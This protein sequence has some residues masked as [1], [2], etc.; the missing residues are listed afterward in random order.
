MLAFGT[1]VEVSI[2]TADEALAREAADTVRAD[3]EYMHR[4]WHPWERGALGRTNQLLAMG[5]W[6]SVNPSVLPLLELSRELE[7]LSDGLFNPAMGELI[8]LWGFHGDERTGEP[9]P[10]E[11]RIREVLARGPSMDHIEIDGIRA[12]ATR[13]GIRLDPGGF[14]KGY[15]VDRAMERLIDMGIEH[16]IINAGGDL[17]AIGRPGDRPWRIGIRH[18]DGESVIASLELGGDESVYT[19]GDYERFFEFDGMRYHHILDPRTGRPARDT[20]SV[21]V[22]HDDGALADAAATAL[23]VAGPRRFA[24]IAQRMGVNHALLIDR[25]GEVFMTPAMAGR[26]RFEAQP[27]PTVHVV[28][29]PA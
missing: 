4:A 19:S 27:A 6:F 9:P 14:A 15:G 26:I 24:E 1:L 2:Y 18:P 10:D 21:T 28:E 23:F 11:A 7:R 29:P 17:R 25:Q 12:R 3:L 5:G 20:R 8:A 16:A 13:P 22:L